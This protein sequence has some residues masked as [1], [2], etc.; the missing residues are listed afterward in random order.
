MMIEFLMIVAGIVTWLF[1]GAVLASGFG[2]ACGLGKWE[3]DDD[4]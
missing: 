2:H 3:R 1:V 4:Q